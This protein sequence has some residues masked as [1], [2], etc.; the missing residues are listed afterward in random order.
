MSTCY[1]KADLR[2]HREEIQRHLSKGLEEGKEGDGV[3]ARR[4]AM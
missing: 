4:V 3:P 2:K 1:G